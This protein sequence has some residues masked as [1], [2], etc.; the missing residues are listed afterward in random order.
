VAPSAHALGDPG[1]GKLDGWQPQ[2]Y[3][4][5]SVTLALKLSET[6]SKCPAGECRFKGKVAPFACELPN[7]LEHCATSGNRNG[8][9][10]KRGRRRLF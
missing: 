8:L 3:E 2:V 1:N 9:G 5:E 7:S 10:G 6:R 4:V